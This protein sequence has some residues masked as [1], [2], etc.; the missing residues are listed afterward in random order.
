MFT[1]LKD[2][3]DSGAMN[4]SN[5]VLVL[6]DSGV[7][8]S[9]L[10]NTL[11][12][13]FNSRP[14]STVGCAVQVMAHQYA[15]G[16]PQE[17][18]DLMEQWDIGGSSLHRKTAASVFFENV[19]GVIFIHDLSNSRSEE[20]LIHWSNMLYGR[21]PVQ[22]GINPPHRITEVKSFLD[23]EQSG[24][25]PT[26][27]IGSR[28]D[29]APQRAREQTSSVIRHFL[30]QH[31]V[32]YLDCRK[33]IPA[34]STNRVLLSRFFDAVIDRCKNTENGLSLGTSRRRRVL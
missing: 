24:Y 25:L 1:V 3:P 31:D 26:V 4:S 19:S 6:G 32:V 28:L 2:F 14:Q 33:E 5:K 21:R 8:K 15:A 17:S 7:G 22:V 23:L 11:C 10:V 27:V 16:T 18:S 29:L 9:T 13:T 34:G 30:P 12:G 20:N